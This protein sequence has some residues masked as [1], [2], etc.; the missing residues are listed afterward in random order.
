MCRCVVDRIPQV[1]DFSHKTWGDFL[2]GL[3][4]ALE[5]DGRVVTVVRFDGVAQPSFRD[6]EFAFRRLSTL[7]VLEVE[8]EAAAEVLAS[9][10]AT[11]R[12]G[13]AVIA[14]SV[15]EMADTFRGTDVGGANE[16]LAEVAGVIGQL[17]LLTAALSKAAGTDLDVLDCGPV[18]G[19]DIVD[20]VGGRLEQ[21]LGA[22]EARDWFAA[23]DCL[24]F[25]LAPAID[26]WRL[27]FD[28]LEGAA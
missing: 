10:A 11:A 25:D 20:A 1:D 4:E 22:Q 18:S 7:D 27:V 24:E 14:H 16:R 2:R 21:L 3:D 13:V 9:T 6:P 28:A 12:A 26:R 15:R 8:T 17:T 23:A 5:P 19:A